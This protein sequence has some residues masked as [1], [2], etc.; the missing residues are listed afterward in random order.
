MHDRDPDGNGIFDEGNGVTVRAS[1]DS[2]GLEGN[3]ASR[4][5]Y[6][7]TISNDGRL[8]VFTSEAS[9]LVT[10]DVNGVTDIFVRDSLMGSTQQL[11]GSFY[12]YSQWWSH[13]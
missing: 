10:G 1:I 7:H 4:V 11:T 2:F 12:S 5:A 3:G 6:S 13:D 9:D 8:V